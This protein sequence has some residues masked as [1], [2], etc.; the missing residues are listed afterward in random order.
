MGTRSFQR[1][2]QP[3]MEVTDDNV[4]TKKGDCII[5]IYADKGAQKFKE[6][7]CADEFYLP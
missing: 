5:G 2:I 3:L 1:P 7:L 6:V 4:L